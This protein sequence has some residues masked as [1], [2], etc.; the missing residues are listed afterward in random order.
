MKFD[1]KTIKRFIN[2]LTQ[3][4][5]SDCTIFHGEILCSGYGR[6]CINYKK[7]V[8]HRISYLIFKGDIPENKLVLHSCDNRRC[9]NPDHLFLGT[10]Q[11]NMDDKVLKNRQSKGE[12]TNR[13]SLDETTVIKIREIRKNKKMK[14]KDIALLFNIS[15]PSAGDICRRRSWKHVI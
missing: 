10:Y 9:V 11:S 13:T 8:A 5:D 7:I 4:K 2:K 12:L 1:L 3:E 15:T 14:Y 6:M